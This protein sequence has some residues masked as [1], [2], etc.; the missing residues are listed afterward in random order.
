MKKL[1]V[2]I[3]F[4]KES[5]YGMDMAVMLSNHLI[6]DIQM[7]YVQKKSSDFSPGSAEEEYNYAKKNFEKIVEEYTPKIKGD[8]KLD[9][10]I[11]KGKIFE[12]VVSQ[13]EAFEDSAIVASTHGGSGFEE[14]FIG[15]NAF[16]IISATDRPVFSIR[17]KE[18]PE[19]IDK[20]IMPL[21]LSPDSRQKVPL[22]TEIAEKFNA[23]IHV[24]TVGSSEGGESHKKLQIYAKQA[25]EYI[26]NHGVKYVMKALTGDSLI[27]VALIYAKAVDA[28][29]VSIMSEQTS[30]ISNFVLGNQA[31]QMINKSSI[32]VLCITPKEFHIRGSFR[33]QG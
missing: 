18:C 12:E 28:G 6:A 33:A 11:K 17:N 21:D 13:A 9:F 15:S 30:A 3:D 25:C 26:E 27:E 20:I 32:P 19:T 22:T 2:P 5:L 10:I 24:I 31:Q 8:Q 29:L 7:V 1:I 16:K 23:E 14:L 4:S